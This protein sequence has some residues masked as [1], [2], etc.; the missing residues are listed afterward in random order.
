MLRQEKGITLVALIVTIIILI[1]LAG[2]TIAS[3]GDKDHGI[4]KETTDAKVLNAYN[5][6][7]EQ[8]NLAYST[9]KGKV[10]MESV[11]DSSYDARKAANIQGF[12]DDIPNDL[13]GKNGFT[14]AVDQTVTKEGT[15]DVTTPVIYI[16]YTDVS[17]KEG[18][19]SK[20]VEASE[21]VPEQPAQPRQDGAIYAKITLDAQSVGYEFNI[22]KP[23]LPTGKD[24]KLTPSVEE[25]TPNVDK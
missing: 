13:P 11:K 3:L 10:M 21:D 20:K 24:F 18:A 19:I 8:A 6:A 25:K 4:L 16:K 2:V 15:T 1:I 5:S 7:S 14:F 23:T 17:L 9:I 12:I 22:A